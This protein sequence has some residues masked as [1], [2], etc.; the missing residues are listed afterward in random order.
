MNLRI[1]VF[2]LMAL[3]APAVALAK[4]PRLP[5]TEKL[6]CDTAV[7]TA[8]SNCQRFAEQERQCKTQTLELHNVSIGAH[9]TLQHA[10][11]LIRQPFVRDGRV[12]D[13]IAS[14]WACIKSPSGIAYVYVLYTC[15]EN[16][17]SPECA[18]TNKEWEMLYG[19]DGKN[20]TPAIPRRGLARAKALDRI[21][22]RLRL[23]SVMEKPV[24]L[25]GIKY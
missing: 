23:E 19:T 13:A 22:R 8:H 16:D 4:D 18:G 12:L 3:I 15:V 1:R 17:N 11:K 10:G 14:S 2:L 9:A 6:L 25:Q 21:Y 24:Q 7:V 5:D 20:L